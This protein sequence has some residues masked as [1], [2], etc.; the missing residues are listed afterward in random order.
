MRVAAPKPHGWMPDHAAR[1]RHIRDQNYAT[2]KYRDGRAAAAQ[3]SDPCQGVACSGHGR[4]VLPIVEGDLPSCGCDIGY[5]GANC[6][7]DVDECASSP[8]ENE[9]V[10]KDSSRGFVGYRKVKGADGETT[11]VGI[12]VAADAFHCTCRPGFM[13]EICDIENEL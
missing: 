6:E 12:P 13:G 3:G 4:C 10:C 8:C 7:E 9:G 1:M 11:K 2:R 5:A